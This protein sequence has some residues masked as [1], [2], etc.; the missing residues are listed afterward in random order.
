V[1]VQGPASEVAYARLAHLIETCQLPPGW[2]FGNETEEAAKLGMS[3]TPFR[4]ALQRLEQEGLVSRVAK[5]RTFVTKIDPRQF[6]HHMTIRRGLEI[7]L[8]RDLL[9]S[10]TDF[11]LKALTKLHRSQ[12]AAARRG[13]AQAFL[14]LDPEFHLTMV[15]AAGNTAASGVLET[16]WRHINRVRY[17]GSPSR[18]HR[19]STIDEHEAILAALRTRDAVELEAAIR[20]HTGASTQRRLQQIRDAHPLAFVDPAC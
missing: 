2:H 20:L 18:E 6:E 10:G 5:H 17:L 14:E 16:C 19:S 8:L 1:E 11:D 4:E 15:A 13:D 3:R 12:T 9:E 7:E